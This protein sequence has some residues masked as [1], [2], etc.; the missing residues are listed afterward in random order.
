[1]T[2]LVQTLSAQ[3]PAN[4]V[5][6]WRAHNER[7]ILDELMQLVSLPNVA[8]NSADMKVNATLLTTLF[9]RRGFTVQATTGL[10]SPVILAAL[11]AS[12]PRGKIGRAHV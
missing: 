4:S 1:M 12:A 8:R 6:D 7:K 9:E 11:S 3:R 10:G 5:A 2:P